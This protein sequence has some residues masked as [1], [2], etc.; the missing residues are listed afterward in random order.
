[1]K[2]HLSAQK[3]LRRVIIFAATALTT[4]AGVWAQFGGGGGTS[5]SPYLINN[6]EQLAQLATYVNEGTTP[7]ANEGRHYKLGEDIDLSGN[8]DGK[9]W[10][11]IGLNATYPF[12]GVFEGNDKKITGLYINSTSLANA[13]LFGYTASS[14]TIRNLGVVDVNI[15]ISEST[16][17][18]SAG[19]VAGYNNGS[20]L[21]CYSIGSVTT[22]STAYSYAGG[23]I[24]RNGS[25]SVVTKCYSA[26]SIITSISSDHESNAGG[27]IGYNTFCNISNCYATGLIVSSSTSSISSTSSAGGVVGYH[28][29]G[30]VSNC[31]ATGSV[32]SSAPSTYSRAGG[33]VGYLSANGSGY[34]IFNCY[35]TGT[36]SSSGN[37]SR[38]G[39]IVGSLDSS[40]AT[41]SNC[42]ALHWSL[43]CSGA[44]TSFGRITGVSAGIRSN[45]VAFSNMKNPSGGTTW[46]DTGEN[47]MDGADIPATIINTNATIEERFT[48]GWTTQTGKLPGLSGSA[49]DMHLYLLPQIG[50][51]SDP[52]IIKTAGQL[53]QLAT[54]VNERTTPFA[55]AGM[56]YKLGND[57]DLSGYQTGEGWIPIGADQGNIF[58]GNFNGDGYKI[59]GLYINNTSSLY[60]GLFGYIS[61]TGTV[62]NLALVDVSISSTT[63]MSLSMFIGGL[64]GYN[65]GIVTNCYTT[66]T[67][68]S[69]ARTNNVGGLLGC[70]NGPGSYSLGYGTVSFCYS[71]CLVNSFTESHS[72]AGGVVGE[73][74]A[75][76]NISNC[77]STGTVF[78]SAG[79]NSH[80][81]GV[82]GYSW[83]STGDPAS[84]VTK[85][86]ATGSI[87]S[88]GSIAY[89][90]GIVGNSGT[91]NGSFSNCVALNPSLTCN[92][93]TTSYYGRVL[94]QNNISALSNNLGLKNMLNPEGDTYWS[95]VVANQKNG[96]DLSAQS[97]HAKGTIEDIFTSSEWTTQNGKLPGLFGATVDMPAH[98]KNYRIN[99][100]ASPTAGGSVTGGDMYW[101]GENVEVKAT[102]HPNYNFV[103]W[104]END[105]PVSDHPIYQFTIEGDRTLVA[106]FTIKKYTIS[107]SV[108]SGNGTITPNGD[109]VVNHGGSQKF[110]I[111]AGEGYHIAQVLVNDKNNSEAVETC[112]YTFQDVTGD[113]SIV[114][115]FAANALTG[116]AIISNT[117]PCIDDVLTGSLIDGNNTGSLSYVWKVNGTSKASTQNYKV[118]ADDFDKT[119]TLEITS[120]VQTG[121]VASVSTDKVKKKPGPAAPVAPTS[122][123][124]TQNSV[125]LKVFSGYEYRKNTEVWQ[126]SAEFT[127]LTANTSYSFYQRIAETDDTYA[128]PS[129]AE[130]IEVTL[131]VGAEVSPTIKTASLTDGKVGE[132][133]S[134][135]LNATGSEPILWTISEGNLPEGLNLS[136]SGLIFGTPKKAGSF[137]F[138]V[139]VSN[140]AGEALK[141]LSITIAKGE[142]IKI[143]EMPVLEGKTNNSLTIKAVTPPTNG[144]PVE[145]AVRGLTVPPQTG[146]QT[147]RTI[148]GLAANFPYY[149]FARAAENENYNV[150]EHIV[151]NVVFYTDAEGR[152]TG[153]GENQS[154]S[155]LKAWIRNE[156]LHVTGL[157]VG[158]TLNVYN[159]SGALIFQGV[160]TS[161]EADI[162]L[163]DQ[164]VYIVRLGEHT[165][166]VVY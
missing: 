90:G 4:T 145:Y 75:G 113:Q 39:G 134:E 94:G 148:T 155:P 152:I 98:L 43:A 164:G 141:I 50:S 44:T 12:K 89:A 130:L 80:A 73:N 66:G 82:I 99:V 47:R 111:A 140:N 52:Y 104:T 162:P 112:S 108:T 18:I 3:N 45:N 93:V 88:S 154:A 91:V 54:Y 77:Y 69:T 86:Y 96:A 153:T 84:S 136:G 144:Q 92:G 128:S 146:W 159:A 62:R 67:V 55:S 156:M 163:A 71:A 121:M 123:T 64:S 85:C 70:N 150:G 25:N 157:T 79:G 38:T 20:I 102:P 23:V 11:P 57:I 132:T 137:P 133:Y 28:A 161:V 42:A 131:A 95:S 166:K 127:G 122:V 13:G 31:F 40:N 8:N 160:V 78:S 135:T 97:I 117:A 109:V 83:S 74:Y 6:A 1:M 58:R 24:G 110:T 72:S 33:V 30:V 61:S 37:N 151:S 63:S 49:I 2:I 56:Y 16:T 115:S 35:A 147:N 124:T 51:S 158:E 165:V 139:K 59:T 36:V 41:V 100:S 116:A 10:I 5:T 26:N 27:V 19:G 34:G 9:D 125:T 15:T 107:A 120:S 106:N 17:N 143:T 46:N 60:V 53:A 149:L 105:H 87:S 7:Y 29:N 21:N 126:K 114:V 32:S 142:G 14:S 101:Y 103:N 81:G 129:S 65:N 68:I 119:I 138:T 76:G 22:S 48:E 118:E